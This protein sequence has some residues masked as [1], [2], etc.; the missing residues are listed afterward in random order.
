MSA[1]EATAK[2][3]MGV[4]TLLSSIFL[5]VT[6]VMGLYTVILV[7]GGLVRT[8]D[9]H[10]EYDEVEPWPYNIDDWAGGRS[11]WFDNIN[12]S[13]VDLLE[14]PPDN[15]D[16]LANTTLFIVSPNNPPQLWRSSSYDAYDGQNWD[17]SDTTTVPFDAFISAADALSQGNTIYTVTLNVSAGPNIGSLEMPTL[18]PDIQVIEDSFTAE[19]AD[20]LISYTWETDAYGSLLFSPLVQ[21]TPGEIVQITYDI[22]YAEQDLT[23]VSENA[24][25]GTSAPAGIRALYSDVG[26]SLS[27]TVLDEIALFEDVGDNAYDKAIA[28]DAYFKTAYDLMIAPDEYQERPAPGEEITEWFINRGGGLPM[29]FSTAYCVFM[30]ELGVPARPVV[31]YA[32]GDDMGTHRELM[33]KHMFFWAEV[34][35]PMIV[36]GEWVQLF[37]IPGLDE[38]PENTGL[39]DVQLIVFPTT[40]NNDEPWVFIGEPFDLSAILLVDLVPTGVGELIE[41]FDMTDG[42]FLGIQTIE[43]GTNFPSA[44]VTYTFPDTA[45][46][47]PH[48]FTAVYDNTPLGV[49][50]SYTMVYAVG[51][52]DPLSKGTDQGKI[53]AEDI[54]DEAIL[55]EIIDVN[56]KLGFDNYTAYWQDTIHVHGLMTYQGVP[57]DGT[58]LDNDQIEIWWDRFWYDNA[59]IQSDGTYSLDIYADPFDSRMGLGDHEV[60]SYYAGEWGVYAS[61]NSSISV[62]E[63]WGKVD[64]NFQVDPQLTIPGATV[65]YNGTLTLLNGTPLSG[66]SIYFYFNDSQFDIKFTDGSGGF[67][68]NYILGVAH[69][70]GVF[71][72]YVNWTS[73]IPFVAGNYS[74]IIDVTISLSATELTIDSTPIH[75]GVLH[76]G[77]TITIWGQLSNETHNLVGYDIDIWWDPEFGPPVSLGPVTTNGTGHYEITVQANLTDEGLLTYWAEFNPTLPGLTASSSDILTIEVRKYFIEVRIFVDPGPL[78]LNDTVTIQGFVLVP[79]YPAVLALVDVTIWWNGIN[80]TVATT[81]ILSGLFT[82]QYT[83]PL[84]HD[85]ENISIYAEFVSDWMGFESNVS[86]PEY[87][88][89]TNYATTISASSDQAQ[90]YLNQTAHI[91]GQLT[92]DGPSMN[93]ETVRMRWMWG[94]GTN[95]WY[96]VQTDALGNY[97]FYVPLSIGD[98]P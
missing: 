44:N 58:T 47:G 7:Q 71:P 67:S 79:E 35:I 98:G 91:W 18:F 13:N 51:T 14:P 60:Y 33:V 95:R 5:L 92:S 23:F 63:M 80:L 82:Y 25:S 76:T 77:D 65:S 97:D 68:S 94:N 10:E 88:V 15:L 36:G 57:I 54:P 29:D 17:K 6:I 61:N 19:P 90:Y 78:H 22:T 1:A 55:A 62:I 50:G 75:P 41:F 24:Q 38:I 42:V 46:A 39:G 21:G 49:V 86:A 73:D 89:I 12:Y 69:P 31:G 96:Q 28:L 34:Y 2:R 93:N 45:T 52:P 16:L 37:P 9:P 27:Q 74:E 64:F 11:F 87:R 81:D 83:I 85:F 40:S 8:Q 59:T 26:V 72:A 84:D 66:K 48:N 43:D 3:K 32:I 20:R 4:G 56:V 70:L 53:L 30:R